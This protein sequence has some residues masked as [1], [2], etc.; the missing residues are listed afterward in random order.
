[1][2]KIF[3]ESGVAEIVGSLVLIVIIGLGI[4][5]AGLF[6]LSNP[7][8]EKIPEI[9]VNFLYNETGQ[10]LLIHHNGGDSLNRDE[11]Y[12]M[13]DTGDGLVERHTYTI[14]DGSDEWSVGK[15]IELLTLPPSTV[16]II[17]E[18]SGGR[19]VLT[20]ADPIVFGMPSSDPYL[21]KLL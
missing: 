20:S 18:G 12:L 21:R 10:V 11:I 8:P 1:M 6:I 17:F 7:V 2:T 5:I 15:D 4:S 3:P 9:N 14:S 19:R 16:Q 13:V